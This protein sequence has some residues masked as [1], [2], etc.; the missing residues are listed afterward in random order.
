MVAITGETA[1]SF[2]SNGMKISFIALFTRYEYG[3]AV[4]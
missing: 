1:F 4:I 3:I 2:F